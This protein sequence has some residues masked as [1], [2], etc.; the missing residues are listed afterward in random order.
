[1]E[2]MTAHTGVMVSSVRNINEMNK[3]VVSEAENVSAATEE[4]TAAI[5]EMSSSSQR[6]VE[7][8]ETL[9]MA[10]QELKV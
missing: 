9:Q 6:L 4:Q 3:G 10:I 7:M 5:S 8:A 1:I 2:K